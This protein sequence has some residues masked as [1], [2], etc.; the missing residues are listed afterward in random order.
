MGFNE[1]AL[2]IG[3]PTLAVETARVHLSGPALAALALEGSLLPPTGALACGL[4]NEV[5]PA[6][7]L[8]KRSLEKAA[9]LSA[10]P[11]RGYAQV[12]RSLRRPAVEA[13]AAASEAETEQ[14]LDTWFDEETRLRVGEAV[15]RL[16]AK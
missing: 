4:V 6:E 5:V 11:T 9:S 7:T 14:W 16:T 15:R 3:L 1:V 13:I 8:L 12:K 10:V 2:G